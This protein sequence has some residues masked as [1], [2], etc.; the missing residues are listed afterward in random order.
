MLTPATGWYFEVAFRFKYFK[1][2]DGFKFEM[3]DMLDVAKV[4]AKGW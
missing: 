4:F 2:D 3:G 1:Y